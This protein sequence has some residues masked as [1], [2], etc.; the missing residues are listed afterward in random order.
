[1]FTKRIRQTPFPACFHASLNSKYSEDTNP[2]M[3]L[4]D[5]CLACRAAGAYDDLFIIQY[6][7]LYLMESTLAWLEHLPTDS[8]HSWADFKRI[9]V[10]NF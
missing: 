5:F 9:F 1:M 8:I 7:P 4:E 10:G 6:L 2:A 3:W